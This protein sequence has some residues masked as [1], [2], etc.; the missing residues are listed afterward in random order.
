MSML[1]YGLREVGSGEYRY[2]GKTRDLDLRLAQHYEFGHGGKKIAEHRRTSRDGNDAE[3]RAWIRGM[4]LVEFVG[5]AEILEE[6]PDVVAG[7][8]ELYWMVTLRA[9]GNRLFCREDLKVSRHPLRESRRN[10]EMLK[11]RMEYRIAASGGPGDVKAI[12]RKLVV[13]GNRL[14][15]KPKTHARGYKWSKP[16]PQE[17]RK[18]ISTSL[19]GRTATEKSRACSSERML[20]RWRNHRE[21]K[22]PMPLLKASQGPLLML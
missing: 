7:L 5:R 17:A 20:T 2:V 9:A 18:R 3:F 1:I 14:G 4:R 12:H 21:G 8:A 11:V 6:V 22:G 10:P 19:T 16:Y 13:L 15:K